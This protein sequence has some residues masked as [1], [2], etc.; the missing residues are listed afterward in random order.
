MPLIF[1]VQGKNREILLPTSLSVSA[2]SMKEAAR[3]GMGII[4][5]P[6][7]GLLEDLAQGKFGT[8]PGGFPGRFTAGFPALPA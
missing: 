3:R 7:Y 2:E 8:N 4:Q 5:V 6:H 1:Q